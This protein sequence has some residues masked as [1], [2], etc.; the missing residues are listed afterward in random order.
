MPL[1]EVYCS[2][3]ESFHIVWTNETGGS[4]VVVDTSIWWG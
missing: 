3:S 1:A 4:D 2:I